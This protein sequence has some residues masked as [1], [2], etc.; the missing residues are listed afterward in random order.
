MT[1]PN[2]DGLLEA[3]MAE[4]ARPAEGLSDAQRHVAMCEAAVRSA[5]V[6]RPEPARTKLTVPEAIRASVFLPLAA[7]LSAR[8]A[9]RWRRARF[10][11]SLRR[12]WL[13]AHSLSQAGSQS[14]LDK[15][16]YQT[17]K[18]RKNIDSTLS[19]QT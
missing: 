11:A 8:E 10:L 7:A 17:Q 5:C 9:V 12:L 13:Q 3:K 6:S 14:S 16:V 15:D 19:K 1:N 4:N 2:N 18:I